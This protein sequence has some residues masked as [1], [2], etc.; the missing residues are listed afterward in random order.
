LLT[1]AVP[2]GAAWKLTLDTQNIY[3]TVPAA[4]PGEPSVLSLPKSGGTP[5]ALATQAFPSTALPSGTEPVG[6]AADGKHVFWSDIAA[7]TITQIDTNGANPITIAQGQQSPEDVATDG[8]NVYWMNAGS[9]SVAAS[10]YQAPVGGGTPQLLA[11]GL[12]PG[13][14]ISIVVAGGNVYWTGPATIQSVPVGGGAIAVLAS[15]L[16]EPA[17]IA[18]SGTDV[19]WVSG[20]TGDLQGLL[21]GVSGPTTIVAQQQGAHDIA[22]DGVNLYWLTDTASSTVSRVPIGGGVATVLVTTYGYLTRTAVDDTSVYWVSSTVI[23]RAHK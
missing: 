19:F 9:S 10:V 11:G 8:T 12:S 13:F 14:P 18:A 5:V 22:T 15:N 4:A 17:S 16:D 6:I 2:G 3:W 23:S 20:Q 7:N 1:D 21:M